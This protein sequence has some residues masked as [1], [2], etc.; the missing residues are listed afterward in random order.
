VLEDASLKDQEHAF[1]FSNP[2][3]KFPV[4]LA[5]GARQRL[6]VRYTPKEKSEAVGTLYLVLRRP[7]GN[8]ERRHIS[9]LAKAPTPAIP[10]TSSTQPP[11]ATEP[12][13]TPSSQ[14]PTAQIPDARLNKPLVED[15]DAVLYT[16]TSGTHFVGI[17]PNRETEVHGIPIRN[18]SDR[19]IVIHELRFL[20][21]EDRAF[22]LHNP[23]TLPLVLK[24]GQAHVLF[25]GYAPN[26]QQHDAQLW[27]RYDK[28]DLRLLWRFS[29]NSDHTVDCERVKP[30]YCP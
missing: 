21:N 27:I 30:S 18:R 3:Q 11:T 8:L 25:Y 10:P 22:F 17:Q 16:Q 19:D 20:N 15:P 7:E 13:Y 29:G 6:S 24:P 5:P 1:R 12:G 4:S 26:R 28:Q 9:L 14:P 2:T 23:P